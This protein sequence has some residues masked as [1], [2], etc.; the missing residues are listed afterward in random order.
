MVRRISCEDVELYLVCAPR[1]NESIRDKGDC[2]CF[3]FYKT[4]N[5]EKS[6]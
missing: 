5:N 3:E 2:P 1:C 4:D 6:S